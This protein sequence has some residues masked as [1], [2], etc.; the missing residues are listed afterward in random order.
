MIY[1]LQSVSYTHLD[2]YKRQNLNR[3]YFGGRFSYGDYLDFGYISA[4]IEYGSFFNNGKTE[5]TTIKI[6]TNYFTNLFSIGSWKFRQFVR[7]VLVLGNNRLNTPKDRLNL[8]DV[9]GIPG[10]NSSP[11][12]GTRK[13]LT[14]FQTPVSYTHLDVYKRQRFS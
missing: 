14:T 9:N 8:I 1:T 2:V 10:F 5:Q 3:A 7:P 4:N 11:L 13:F 6:E 12:V